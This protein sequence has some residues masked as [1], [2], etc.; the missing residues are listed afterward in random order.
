MVS[1]RGTG[2]EVSD[3][4]VWSSDA[5]AVNCVF[6]IVKSCSSTDSTD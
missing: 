5:M 1:T 4:V 2:F 6:P 3:V